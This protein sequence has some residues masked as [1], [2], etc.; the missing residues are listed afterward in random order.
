MTI[1]GVRDLKNQLPKYLN[2]VKKGGQVIVTDRGKPIAI[3][4]DLAGIEA[5]AGR[6]EI[7]ASLAS[8]GK[9]RLPVRAGGTRKF[10]GVSIKG[11]SITCTILED[12]R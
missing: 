3:I 8:A 1:V 5:N 4:H 7:L 10:D 12:R 6:D 11:K 2:M 9:V